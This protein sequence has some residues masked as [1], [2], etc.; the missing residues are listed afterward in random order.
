MKSIQGTKLDNMWNFT[1]TGVES[2]ETVS[3]VVHL[4]KGAF[5]K[6]KNTHIRHRVAFLFPMTLYLR[7]KMNFSGKGS[8]T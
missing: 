7:N 6:K 2:R 3:T 4:I 5:K 1:D 8:A